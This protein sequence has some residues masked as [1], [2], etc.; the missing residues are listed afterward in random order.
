MGL[1]MLWERAY[2]DYPGMTSETARLA[3]LL[4]Q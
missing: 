2:D 1:C 4:R 3:G